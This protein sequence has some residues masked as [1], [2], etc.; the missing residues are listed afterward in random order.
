M[1]ELI[2]NFEVNVERAAHRRNVKYL[3]LRAKKSF[4]KLIIK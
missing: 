2:R 1:T 3:W 4:L